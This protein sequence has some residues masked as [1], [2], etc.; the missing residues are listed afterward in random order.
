LKA[1]A[2]GLAFLLWAATKTDTRMILRDV[3][4]RVVNSDPEWVMTGAPDPATVNIRFSGPVRELLRLTSGRTSVDIRMLNVEDSLA[5]F[6]LRPGDVQGLDA[7][8]NTRVE[9][10]LADS[11]RLAFEPVIERVMPVAVRTTGSPPSGLELVQ[12]PRSIPAAV[13][14]RGAASRVFAFDSI[15]LPPIAL[16]DRTGTDTVRVLVPVT[17]L[18]FISVLPSSVEIVVPLREPAPDTARS[19]DI[20]LTR[21]G[22]R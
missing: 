10:I 2:V 13:R 11:V 7:A 15:I 20:A 21:G 5:R 16:G 8:E 6:A 12:Q 19:R 1:I 22:A 9:A 18:G 14:V 4:V 3:P 17:D